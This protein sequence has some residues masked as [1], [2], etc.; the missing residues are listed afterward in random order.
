MPR[1]SQ[2]SRRNGRSG[3]WRYVGHV[4]IVGKAGFVTMVSPKIHWF[5]TIFPHFPHWNYKCSIFVLYFLNFSQMFSTCSPSTLPCSQVFLYFSSIFPAEMAVSFTCAQD[6][7]ILHHISILYIYMYIIS[8]YI[9]T[10]ISIYCIYIHIYIFLMC[11]YTLFG[12]L[13]GFW[14]HRFQK[15]S[16]GLQGPFAAAADPGPHH[17]W[18]GANLHALSAAGIVRNGGL[19]NWL[20]V[21]NMAEI[22][23]PIVGMMIQSDWLICFRGLKPPTS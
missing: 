9:Y 15:V 14:S 1:R 6:L 20:V 18:T 16:S 5:V 7:H 2:E 8:I 22:F 19:F 3:W 23:S 17:G 12:P 13:N 10:Y 21:W 11:V 4:G